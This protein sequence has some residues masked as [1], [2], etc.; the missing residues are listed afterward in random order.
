[1]EEDNGLQSIDILF[2]S[3]N[4]KTGSKD[5]P[6]FNLSHKQL[7]NI[8]GL[9]LLYTSIPFSY[10]VID[11]TNNTFT[12]VDINGTWPIVIVPGTYNAS[13]LATELS[14]SLVVAGV[15][16]PTHYVFYVDSSTAQLVIYNNTISFVI[17]FPLKTAVNNLGF[18]SGLSSTNGLLADN[19]E[20]YVNSGSATNYIVSQGPVSLT[21]S[22][23]IYLHSPELSSMLNSKVY[24]D[25]QAG[26]ILFVIPANA[27]YLG[28]H[29][30]QP[31][32]N[33]YLRC[34]PTSLSN[35]SFYLTIGNQTLYESSNGGTQNF[36]SLQGLPFQVGIRFYKKQQN[37][38]GGSYDGETNEV[39]RAVD[40]SGRKRMRM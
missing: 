15:T 30:F 26:D 36:L 3:S 25:T 37:V 24:N 19:T 38:I 17:S 40:T 20:T 27:S 22:N 34:N 33:L 1:M 2:D 10:Y 28:I 35:M 11:I 8:V 29:E 6:V 31:T 23:Q 9:Q 32:R 16:L 13:N 18:T 5:Y 12:L 39:R 7:D 4:Y 14:Q 21:G